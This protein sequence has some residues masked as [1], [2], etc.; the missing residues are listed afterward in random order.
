M[1]CNEKASESTQV[2]ELRNILL[3]MQNQ[4]QRLDLCPPPFQGDL[5]SYLEAFRRW[6]INIATRLAEG[7]FPGTSFLKN[8]N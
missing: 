2:V 7:K 3:S 1:A 8:F 5:H 4:L 6:L